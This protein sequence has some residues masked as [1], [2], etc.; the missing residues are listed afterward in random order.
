VHLK[1]RVLPDKRPR[2][3]RVVEVDVAQEQVP[4][5]AQ[6]P[7]ALRQA[8]LER[9]DGGRRAAVEE[10]EPVLRVEQVAADDALGAEMVEID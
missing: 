10:R 3:A 9:G 4:E 2:G 8:L 5:V 1:A 7:P 6:R